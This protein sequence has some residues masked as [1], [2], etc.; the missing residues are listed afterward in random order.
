MRLTRELASSVNFIDGTI[1]PVREIV[2]VI[3]DL[4]L[5]P[6]QTGASTDAGGGAGAIGNLPGIEH[7][8][9]FGQ[10]RSIEGEGGWRPWLARWLGRDDLA[11][12]APAVIAAAAASAVMPAAAPVIAPVSASGIALTS[13]PSIPPPSAGAST[14]NST[15]WIATPVHLIAGLT[16]LH[17]DRRSIL[18][19]S[20]TDCESFATD[21]NRTFAGSDLLLKPLPSG[22]FLLHGSAALTGST[23]EPARALVANLEA[24]LPKGADAKPLKRLGAELEMWLHATPLNESRQRRGELSVSTLWLW[25]GGPHVATEARTVAAARGPHSSN[26]QLALS[27]GTD[28]YLA[29]LWNLQG[30]RTNALPDDQLASL[31]ASFLAEDGH[32]QRAVLVTE[33]T[34][35]LHSNPQWTVFDALAELDRL[36]ASPA[37]DA[38][39]TGI[40]ERVV[41]IANDVEVRV[42]RRDRLK[43]WRRRQSILTG[44]QS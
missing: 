29:G 35:L 19:L 5:V 44:L 14:H 40:L 27:F 32:T 1:P 9:R 22:D 2:I 43:F 28:P 39:R 21:F 31:F 38:L 36:Y 4:Y 15:V 17:L 41:L 6:G 24:S 18:R 7:V 13:P 23:T 33:V 10:R 37:I 12:V 8:A 3:S 42:G 25:G 34:P 26:A 16:S 20:P 11:G 30:G